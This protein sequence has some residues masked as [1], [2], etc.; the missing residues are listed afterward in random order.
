MYRHKYFLLFATAGWCD[1]CCQ[2]KEQLAQVAQFLSVREFEDEPVVILTLDSVKDANVLKELEIGFFKV[3]TLF[4]VNNKKFTQFNSFFTA[5]NIIRFVNNLLHPV[6]ELH[7]VEQV[8]AFMNTTMHYPENNAFLD[9]FEFHDDEKKDFKYRN[10]LV[11]FFSSLEDYSAEYSQFL[12]IA[13]NIA[14]KPDLRIGVVLNK[15]ITKHFKDIYDGIWFNSHSWNSLVLKRINQYHFLDLSLLNEHIEVFMTYN[16]VSYIDELSSNTQP[17]VSKIS[18]PLALFFI[19]T[20]Y[21]IE[22]FHGQMRFLEKI[23]K[24]YVGKYVFLYMDGNIFTQ[25]KG[26]VGM[27]KEDK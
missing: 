12:S 6:V 7:T 1:Y 15:D 17:I 19:D 20:S 2:Q 4:F 16:T 23:A 24:D 22:N 5:Q 18:T 27:K 8:E 14:F 9:R 13:Q 10:R 25:A 11:G 21:V 3:P 26:Q